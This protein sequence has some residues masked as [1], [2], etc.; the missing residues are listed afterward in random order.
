MAAIPSKY[1]KLSEEHKVICES[2][3]QDAVESLSVFWRPGL[4]LVQSLLRWALQEG[5]YANYKLFLENSDTNTYL[6]TLW[7]THIN[8]HTHTLSL[9]ADFNYYE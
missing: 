6:T 2:V 1:S 5:Y 3:Q 8:T 9:S 7:T 4:V